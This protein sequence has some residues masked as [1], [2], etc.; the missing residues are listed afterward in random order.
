MPTALASCDGCLARSR[1]DASQ[2][3]ERSGRRAPGL[4]RPLHAESL[5]PG[6]INFASREA[7]VHEPPGPADL[8]GAIHRHFVRASGVCN[9]ASCATSKGR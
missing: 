3:P 5:W 1:L 2:L 8:P 4:R 7:E 6:D 9:T